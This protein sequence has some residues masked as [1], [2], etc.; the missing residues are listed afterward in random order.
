MLQRSQTKSSLQD[1]LFAQAMRLKN[2]ANTLPHGPLRDIAI[3]KARQTEIVLA[4]ITRRQAP[5]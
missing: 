4:I 5:R 2:E 3:R 1:R